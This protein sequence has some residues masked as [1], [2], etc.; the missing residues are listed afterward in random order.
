MK[1]KKFLVLFMSV[2]MLVTLLAGCGQNDAVGNDGNDSPEPSAPAQNTDDEQGS[3]EEKDKFVIGVDLFYK[4]DEYYLD[5]ETCMRMRAEELGVDLV[6]QNAD[7]DLAT[8]VQQVEDFITKGVDAI[9]I[10]A[11][12]PVGSYACVEA[13]NAANIPIFMFDGVTENKEG[14]VAHTMGDFVEEGVKAGEWAKKY[15]EENL[16][17]EATYA[18]LDFFPSPIICGGRTSGFMS[19]LDEIDGIT[20]V[21]HQDG[22]ATREGG[23]S[24]MEDILTANNNDVDLVFAINY[25]SGAGA[26]SA[27]EAAGADTKVIC[28]SWNAEGFE[29]LENKDKYMQA[30]LLAA[31]PTDIA[32]MIDVIYDHLSGETVEKEVFMDSLIVDQETIKDLDWRPIV[33]AREN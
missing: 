22:G 10:S 19:V 2:V 13:A 9:L 27:I 17:G 23:M 30:Y 8:Q 14:I 33:E 15:I 32:T 24:V 28:V 12:D 26:A 21:A 31:I 18:V 5:I 29:K 11:V 3:G 6:V 7:T 1:A 20:R 16:D 4:S 25:E